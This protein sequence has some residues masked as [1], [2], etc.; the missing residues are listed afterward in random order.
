MT[1]GGEFDQADRKELREIP[2]KDRMREILFRHSFFPEDQGVGHWADGNV[3]FFGWVKEPPRR[4]WV[5]DARILAY[6]HTL[7]RAII[8]LDEEEI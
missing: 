4:V 1:T 7:F 5:D 2:F 6:D 8:P 3:I